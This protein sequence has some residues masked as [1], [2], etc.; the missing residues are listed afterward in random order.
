MIKLFLITC[1]ILAL[2]F[3]KITFAINVDKNSFLI[4]KKRLDLINN[5]HANFTQIITI[6]NNIIQQGQGEI[7][8]KKPNKF[9]WHLFLPEEMIII[10]DGIT[11]WVYDPLIKQVTINWVKNVI[12]NIPAILMK[13]N[14]YNIYYRQYNI[15]RQ[16]NKFVLFP[17]TNNNLLKKYIITISSIGVIKNFILVNQC[18]QFTSYYFYNQKNNYINNIK[19]YLKLPKDVITDDQR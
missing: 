9:N 1:N 12:D 18:N 16:G 2:I 4:L 19:F 3:I 6:N 14:K 17:K 8:I 11:L 5:F 10:S 7:W 13:D 15:K